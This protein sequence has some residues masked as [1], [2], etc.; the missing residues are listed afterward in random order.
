MARGKA[1]NYRELF[2]LVRHAAPTGHTVQLIFQQ[3]S[4]LISIRSLA[5]KLVRQYAL[6]K[7]GM[8]GKNTLPV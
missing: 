6:I 1:P 5:L 8:L 2:N 7:A 3:N 4:S